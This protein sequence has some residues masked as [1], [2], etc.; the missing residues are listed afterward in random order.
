MGRSF[1][2]GPDAEDFDSDLC[3]WKPIP[4]LQ[5]QLSN[6]SWWREER[7]TTVFGECFIKVSV[8]GQLYSR[9]MLYPSKEFR[10]AL[11]NINSL[12]QA[13]QCVQE[14]NHRCIE[15]LSINCFTNKIW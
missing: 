13:V 2:K 8:V 5:R 6:M 9:N 10:A 11:K 4:D 7:E 15:F 1:L 14:G 3:E 12:H